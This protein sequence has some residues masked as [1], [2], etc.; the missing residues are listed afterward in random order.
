MVGF[1]AGPARA[2]EPARTKEPFGVRATPR[3]IPPGMLSEQL[4]EPLQLGPAKSN[5]F[6]INYDGVTIKYTGQLDNA[7]QNVSMFQDFAR[8]YLPYGEGAKR[9]ASM[10]AIKA[11]WAKYKVTITDT[12]PGAGS[13]TMGVFSPTNP[14]GGGVLG[15]APLDCGDQLASNIVFAYHSATDKFQAATQATTMSQEIAHAYGLEHVMEPNDIM[16]PYNAGG[17]PAFLNK[18]LAFD[19]GGGG[20]QCNAQHAEFCNGAGQNSDA[21]LSALFGQAAPDVAPPKVQ[22]TAPTDGA[23]LPA[24]S[25]F[26]I[27]VDASDD[28]GISKVQL[29]NN[30]ALLISFDAEPFTAP[31]AN[32]PAGSYCFT[33]TATDLANNKA[34]SNEVCITVTENSEPEATTAGPTSDPTS[35]PTADPTADP[36]TTSAGDTGGDSA[37][38]AGSTG[39]EGDGG[40]SEGGS[41]GG[42]PSPDSAGLDPALPPG[43]GQESE[44][45]CSV[46]TTRPL[47]LAG[48]LLLL[49]G[50]LRRR[51]AA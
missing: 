2:G 28:V 13:Y 51:R 45:A 32:I 34:D 5:V 48:L 16:N 6:F 39:A 26:D 30:G 24:G 1:T 15:I 29:F 33:A 11:D 42:E 41:E 7:A 18:C 3:P 40:E 46:Q 37:G 27:V 17:D 9:A 4:P 44:G 43:Y 10:Q 25:D 36:P 50:V 20:I 14:F 31:A 22:I 47:P 21:E 8:T 23:V 12:R 38:S 35:D 19:Q 49:L